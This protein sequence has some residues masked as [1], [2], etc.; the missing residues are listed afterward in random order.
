M[1]DP[2]LTPRP[3]DGCAM[4]PWVCVPDLPLPVREPADKRRL[5][6][7]GTEQVGSGHRSHLRRVYSCSSQPG[8][9]VRP[10]ASL[11]A[12]LHGPWLTPSCWRCTAGGWYGVVGAGRFFS[13]I[14]PT[15][16]L[17]GVFTASFYARCPTTGC[18]TAPRFRLRSPAGTVIYQ[19]VSASPWPP[20]SSGWTKI[21]TTVP[22]SSVTVV[23]EIFNT[24][25]GSGVFEID[26]AQICAGTSTF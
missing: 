22:L 13:N 21:S 24:L 4:R 7:Y 18:G 16:L 17:S 25:A 9:Y 8:W 11:P 5:R 14:M 23:F 12:R 20:S 15:N 10:P 2:G 1:P 26:T 6:G 19:D 3:T